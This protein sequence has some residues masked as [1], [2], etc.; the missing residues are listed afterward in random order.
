MQGQRDQILQG[1]LVVKAFSFCSK[2][3]GGGSWPSP[4]VERFYKQET[5]SGSNI[6]LKYTTTIVSLI[7]FRFILQLDCFY[8]QR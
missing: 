1:W 8:Y 2:P 6:L 3:S 5:L 4:F 7:Y